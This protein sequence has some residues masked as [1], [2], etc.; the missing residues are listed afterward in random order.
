[1]VCQNQQLTIEQDKPDYY[2]SIIIE[3]V[4]VERTK[5]NLLNKNKAKI[6]AKEIVL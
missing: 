3:E 6:K 2:D 1:M 5:Q 4:I